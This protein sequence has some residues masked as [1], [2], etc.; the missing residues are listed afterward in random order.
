MKNDHLASAK[1]KILDRWE[2]L[3]G[4]DKDNDVGE[5][6]IFFRSSEIK[7]LMDELKVEK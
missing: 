7:A 1:K 3:E 5:H 2:G 4:W 6:G